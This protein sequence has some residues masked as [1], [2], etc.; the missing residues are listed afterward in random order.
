MSSVN[1]H[2]GEVIAIGIKES[3]DQVALQSMQLLTID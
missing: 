2:L 1:V 3:V